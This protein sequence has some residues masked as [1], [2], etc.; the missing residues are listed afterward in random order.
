MK[1]LIRQ[2]YRRILITLTS[3]LFLF[4]S[5]SQTFTSDK[6]SGQ[7]TNCLRSQS[8]N[9]DLPTGYNILFAGSGECLL[10]HNS[11]TDA[12]G[13]PIGILNDWRSTMMANSAKDPFWRAKV[14]HETLVNPAHKEALEDVCIRCHAPLGYFDAHHL[15]QE[16]YSID[17]M[18]SDSLALDGISCTT[19]HQITYE[20]L[21]SY[22]GNLLIGISKQIWGP[23]TEPFA[24]PMINQTGYTPAYGEHIR[25]AGLCGSCHTLITN[26]VDENGEP[27]GTVFVE[28]AIYHEWLNSVYPDMGITCQACHVPEIPDTVKISLMPPWLDGRSP[29]GKHHFAGANVFMQKIFS[30]NIEELGI[31]AESIHFD[32]TLSRINSLLTE[33][34]IDLALT[35]MG[36]TDDTLSFQLS[37]QNLAGHKLPAGFPSRRVFLELLLKNEENDT[38]FHSG[39]LDGNFNLIAEDEDFEPH[40]EVI[41]SEAQVQIYEMVMGDIEGN[42]TTVLE[43]AY[44]HLKDNR[45]PPEGFAMTHSSYDTAEI[46]GLA[47]EDPNF[48]IEGETEGTGSDILFVH[49]PISDEPGSIEVIVRVFYQT[50]SPRWLNDM[51]EYN[52]DEIDLWE[53]LYNEAEKLPLLLKEETFISL[54]TETLENTGEPLKIY[55][56]PTLGKIRVDNAGSQMK[57]IVIYGINGEKIKNIVTDKEHKT[58]DL[59]GYKGLYFVKVV[60]ADDRILTK[61][62][63]VL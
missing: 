2:V 21:G 57:E 5:Y 8:I 13:K 42:V 10:C 31:T 58:I 32:S 14:S 16:Y 24:P 11:M 12:G 15:G 34:S 28:Q 23:Y 49:A 25:N 6:L 35:E 53:A 22:S 41:N 1:I 38:I 30:S 47:L 33:A 46:A 43:R 3:V 48:N 60:F 40:H 61:R 50:V 7:Q 52:S 36:R 4:P 56:N 63:I 18:V 51:F 26:S 29:F 59:T 55:P 45:I 27:T 9:T 20:T 39:K 37:I 19:C 54:P 17:E 44:Q 62:V